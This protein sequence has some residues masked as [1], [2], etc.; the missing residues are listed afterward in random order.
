MVFTAAVLEAA[1]SVFLSDQGSAD[2]ASV[3]VTQAIDRPIDPM[4][5]PTIVVPTTVG[6][7]SKAEGRLTA[8]AAI[9]PALTDVAPR[10]FDTG[11]N[12][13]THP[14]IPGASFF[15]TRHRG[16]ASHFGGR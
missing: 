13:P 12:L 8:S 16:L 11:I 15:L 2:P 6:E 3:V 4:V 10:T 1:E 9:R 14:L 7:V 5:T